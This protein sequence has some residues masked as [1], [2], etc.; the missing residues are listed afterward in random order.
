LVADLHVVGATRLVIES[1][2]GRDEQDRRTIFAAL[3]EGD[4][5][6]TLAYEHM[7]PHEEPLLWPA[8]A[9]GWAYSAGGDWRRR[10]DPLLE[11]VTEL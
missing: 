3:R 6:A 8:D 5:H 9:I 2:S 10:A 1:R 7:R 11:K 4:P